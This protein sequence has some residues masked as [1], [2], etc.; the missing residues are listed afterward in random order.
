MD[1]KTPSSELELSWRQRCLPFIL[2][3]SVIVL[4]QVT[5]AVVVAKIPLGTIAASYFGDFLQIWHVRNKAVAFSM[6]AGLPD[7]F[8]SILFLVVP[9]VVMVLLVWML[10]SRKNQFTTLQRWALAG[11]LGGGIGNLTDRF[12]RPDGVVDF[13]SVKFYGLFGLDRWP[14]FNVADSS[15][16]VCGILLVVSLIAAVHRE[17]THRGVGDQEA[18]RRKI[19]SGGADSEAKDLKATKDNKAR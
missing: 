10:L 16:V 3:I 7:G 4:D 11:I 2:T 14:T 19:V 15:V 6:G 17:S 13:V 9:T 5:K 12:F 1:E 18:E 8:R